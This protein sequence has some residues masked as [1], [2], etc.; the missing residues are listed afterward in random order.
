MAMKC[1]QCEGIERE[2]NSEDADSEIEAYRE[3][4]PIET[5]QLLIDA[6]TEQ[7]VDQLTLLDIGGG[8]GAI[9]HAMLSAGAS[10]ATAVEASTAFARA[11]EDE[12]SELGWSEQVEV[13]QGNFVDLAESVPQHD[14]VTLDRVICCYHD[15]KSLVGLSAARAAKFYGLVYPRDVWWNKIAFRFMDLFFWISRSPFRT[16]IHSDADVKKVLNNEGLKRVF[17]KKLFTWQVALY[18]RTS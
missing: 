16:F 9:Q 15:M 13:M 14:I 1:C 8:V 7:G 10:T 2:F 5:T 6:L 11:A 18:A 17:H 4:G 12:A 3:E